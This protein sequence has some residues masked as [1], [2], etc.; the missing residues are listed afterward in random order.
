MPVERIA[1]EATRSGRIVGVRV[2]E[3]TDEEEEAAPWTRPP[4]GVPRPSR[5]GAD[6]GPDVRGALATFKQ[7]VALDPVGRLRSLA[8]TVA[9]AS[10]GTEDLRGSVLDARAHNDA[11]FTLGFERFEELCIEV[12]RVGYQ[13]CG[14]RHGEALFP[15][16]VAESAQH[17]QGI[18]VETACAVSAVGLDEQH[19]R[20]EGFG[21]PICDRRPC[22]AKHTAQ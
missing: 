15:G 20:P 5:P 13:P 14:S 8:P 21:V 11:H 1:D 18:L 3:P 12:R 10:A 19:G 7:S 2:A 4:S 6:A 22:C 9:L 16:S 17:V